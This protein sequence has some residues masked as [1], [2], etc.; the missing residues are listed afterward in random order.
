MDIHVFYDVNTGKHTKVWF[1]NDVYGET[2]FT[3]VVKN[4]INWKKKTGGMM[5]REL[6]F[7]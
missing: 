1:R 7:H 4:D 2:S 3:N 6:V 5:N